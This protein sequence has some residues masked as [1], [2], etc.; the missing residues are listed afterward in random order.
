MRLPRRFAPRNDC[1]IKALTTIGKNVDQSGLKNY[2]GRFP[3]KLATTSY[4]YPDEIAP[5]V[6]RL[7]PSFDE[8][9]LVLFESRSQDSIQIKRLMELS[10]LHRVGFNVHLPID[11]SLGDASEKIRRNGISVVKKL[12]EQTLC[13]NPSLYT[14]HLEF[15]NPPN[16]P[17]L[18][19]GS[20][21]GEEIPTLRG[22]G[23]FMQD[24]DVE[25]WRR[26]LVQCLE[27][28]MDGRIESKRISI[29]NLEYPFEWIEDI[30]R[31]FRFSI[32]L[33]VGHILIH[34][35][36]LRHYL[37]KYL[38]ETSII[39]LYGIQN[40]RDHLGIGKLS[41]PV[42]KTILSCLHHYH[43]IVSIEVFSIDALK[44]SLAIL[45][46]EWTVGKV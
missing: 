37:E 3:F 36:D 11:I 15:I 18:K 34:G 32:C 5:N 9:E 33:D 10:S 2:R 14:L 30:V 7:A 20:P 4:I 35:H 27:E 40:G 22:K 43:G 23:G 12:I 26:R 31:D 44:S 21:R 42:L 19:G 39:H 25:G 16:P 24:P 46:E 45:E 17:L 28:I 29:E 1:F 6:A 8:I 13:L 38:P 41:K